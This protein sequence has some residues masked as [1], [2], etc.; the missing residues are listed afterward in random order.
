MS[1][2]LSEYLPAKPDVSMD[3]MAVPFSRLS[4]MLFPMAWASESVEGEADAD[5][6]LLRE[7][8]PP[9][10]ERLIRDMAATIAENGKDEINSQG[11]Q[12]QISS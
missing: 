6:L 9:A 5:C 4:R 7:D 8:N 2:S 1:A 10:R 12:S 11:I 3:S